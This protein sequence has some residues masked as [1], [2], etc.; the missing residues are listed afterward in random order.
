[1]YNAIVLFDGDELTGGWLRRRGLE[2]FYSIWDSRQFG[3]F[4][5]GINDKISDLYA[6]EPYTY[7]KATLDQWSAFHKAHPIWY[8]EVV[9]RSSS[10]SASAPNISYSAPAQNQPQKRQGLNAYE[11]AELNQAKGRYERAVG[12]TKRHPESARIYE[13]QEKQAYADYMR[14]LAKYAGRE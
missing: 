1:M 13:A 6:I 5:P 9:H 2:T 8:Q 11:R 7:H 12:A 10:Q 14:I 3:K 4:S